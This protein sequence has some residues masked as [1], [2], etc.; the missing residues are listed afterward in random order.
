MIRRLF[1]F[2]FR[3]YWQPSYCGLHHGQLITLMKCRRC[4]AVERFE[5][6]D[7]EEF[8]RIYRMRGCPGAAA[9]KE[10]GNG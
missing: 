4:G 8:V 1:A 5:A 10:T 7:R 3:H 9:E 6:F 2:L